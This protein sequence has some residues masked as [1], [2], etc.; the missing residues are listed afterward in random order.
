[1]SASRADFQEVTQKVKKQKQHIDKT[2]AK[3]AF[4]ADR[5][6]PNKIAASTQFDFSGKNLTPY[7]GLFPVATMLEKLGFQ[8]LVEKM[9]GVKRI[10]RSMTIY[11]FVLG[12]VLAIYLGF[13]RL[14]HIR[15][16]ANDPMLTGVLKV[17]GLPG[18]SVFWRFLASLHLTVARQL[19]QLQSVLRRRVREAANVQLP[20][21]TID[22]DTTVHTLYG[23]QMGARK[24][25]NRMSKKQVRLT[26]SVG[27]IPTRAKVRT[28]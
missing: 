1:V 4:P 15:F 23:N 21:I 27:G 5:P 18:Q 9:L 20:V 14:N 28:L 13:F 12:M 24:G 16:V 11:Q 2:R 17:T 8:E 7:G 6:E 3:Q 10:P 25:Y 26:Y 22:T 19:L